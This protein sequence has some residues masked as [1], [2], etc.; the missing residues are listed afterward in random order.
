[1][2]MEGIAARAGVGKATV[3]RRWASKEELLVD[4]VR[5]RC[6]EPWEVPDTGSVRD[7]MCLLLRAMLL[8]F[9]RNGKVMQAFAGEQGR[10][11]SLAETFRKTFVADRRRLSREIVQR[12]VARG[13]LP[14]D[15]DVELLADVG[16]ALLWHRLT[17]SGA[18]LDDDLPERIVNLSFPAFA[19]AP[20]TASSAE[21]PI[22]G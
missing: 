10:H 8:R 22:R 20:R 18:P 12:G 3:Y 14:P 16:P 5:G 6:L 7:D 21:A 1:M 2:S 4:A 13:Q 11:P 17:V 9:R 19:A 15:T